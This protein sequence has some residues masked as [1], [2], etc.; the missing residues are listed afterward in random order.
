MPAE[1]F[2]FWEVK[3][4]KVVLRVRL[5][6]NAVAEKIGGCFFDAAENE[7]LKVCVTTVPE[8]GKAN[9]SLINLLSKR[10]KIAKSAIKMTGGET[11]R[12]KRLEISEPA[13]DVVFRLQQLEGE[14]ADN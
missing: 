6:P 2:L 9:K 3:D 4:N 13:E 8:K 12:C 7:Y 1:K 10:L 11:E 5:T 14:D